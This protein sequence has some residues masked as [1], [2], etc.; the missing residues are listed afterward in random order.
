MLNVFKATDGSVVR[1]LVYTGC[2]PSL[3]HSFERQIALR[4]NGLVMQSSFR[5]IAGIFLK[6]IYEGH[7]ISHGKEKPYELASLGDLHSLKNILAKGAN[8]PY[9]NRRKLAPLG[10]DL[11]SDGSICSLYTKQLGAVQTLQRMC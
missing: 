1:N 9:P 10:V 2:L 6:H 7:K 4:R 8:Q 5:L 3:P 11:S